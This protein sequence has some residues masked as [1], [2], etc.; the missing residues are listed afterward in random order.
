MAKMIKIFLK[1]LFL[2]LV[3]TMSF[4]CK[5]IY[6]LFMASAADCQPTTIGRRIRC[7]FTAISG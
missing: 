2:V 6:T 3:A 1:C 4:S 5:Y 7:S